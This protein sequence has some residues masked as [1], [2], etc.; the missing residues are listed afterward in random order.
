MDLVGYD[1]VFEVY[2]DLSKKPVYTAN[3]EDEAKNWAYVQYI[4]EFYIQKMYQEKKINNLFI[5]S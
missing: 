1:E 5:T 2:T 4:E 3:S